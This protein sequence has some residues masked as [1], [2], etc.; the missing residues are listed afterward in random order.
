MSDNDDYD[1]SDIAVL[2]RRYADGDYNQD[3]ALMLDAAGEIERLRLQVQLLNEH[4]RLE[5]GG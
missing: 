3:V 1:R 5:L 2:L 4:I